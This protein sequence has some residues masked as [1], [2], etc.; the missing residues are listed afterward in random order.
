MR[1]IPLSRRPAYALRMGDEPE[2]PPFDA[3]E[4]S[5]NLARIK[6]RLRKLS[7]ETQNA[8]DRLQDERDDRRKRRDPE[9]PPP[10]PA[11]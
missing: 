7:L 3:A 9:Q 5:A 4:M 1:G 10:P 6:E 2:E 8:F 11:A